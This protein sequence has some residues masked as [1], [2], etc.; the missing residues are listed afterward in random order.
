VIIDIWFYSIYYIRLD[1]ITAGGHC[2]SD[3]WH[4]ANISWPILH[5]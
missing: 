5:W 1:A 3:N 2:S 4:I